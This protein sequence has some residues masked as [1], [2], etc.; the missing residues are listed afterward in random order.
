MEGQK[1]EEEGD[2]GV[3]YRWQGYSC[4]VKPERIFLSQPVRQAALGTRHGVLLTKDGLVYSFGE[5]PWKRDLKSQ[6]VEPV[7]ESS[8]TGHHVVRVSTGNF[9]CGAVTEEGTVHMWG[10]NSHGQCGIYGFSV[11]PNPT[12]VNIVDDEIVPPELVRIQDVACGAEHTLA[13]SRKHEVWAWGS[14]CQLGLVTTVFPVWKAEKVEHLSGRYV[15]Q[16]VCG[17]F[18][19]LALV[20]SQPRPESLQQSE[21]KCGECKQPIYTFIDKD[22]H[23][24]ISDNHYCPLGVELSDAKQGQK[25]NQESPVLVRKTE[26][27]AHGSQSFVVL[28]GDFCPSESP[29]NKSHSNDT[30]GDKDVDR[31]DPAAADTTPDSSD[32]QQGCHTRSKSSLYPDEQALKDYLKRISEQSQSEQFEAGFMKGSRHG[33]QPPS[34]QTSLKDSYRQDQDIKPT[35]PSL[36]PLDMSNDIKS[37]LSDDIALQPLQ[38]SVTDSVSRGSSEDMDISTDVLTCNSCEEVSD[39]SFSTDRHL[40]PH[41]LLEAKKSVSL[42]DIR[43]DYTD[44]HSRRRS[45]PGL[46]SPVSPAV[47]LR[48]NLAKAGAIN[49][50]AIGNSEKENLLQSLATEVWTWGRGQEGQ[51]GHGDTLPRLQPLCI[52][53]L[54]KK[55]V[56]KIVAGSYHSLALTAQCQVYSWGSNKLGQLGHTNSLR[57]VPQHVKMPDGIRVW[58]VAAGQTHTVLLADAD[59][60]EPILYYSGGQMQARQESP[61]ATYTQTPTLLPFFTNL[62]FV[63]SIFAGGPNCV[64]LVDRN[65]MGY[66]ATVHKMATAE[67]KF[68]CML[69]RVKNQILHPILARD[70]V[71]SCLSRTSMLLF[72]TMA[73]KY[74]RLCHLIG[75]HATSLTNFLQQKPDVKT[76]AIL[77]N[78]DLFL[79]T[80]KKH[81]SSVGNFLV[82]GGF[83]SLVKPSQECFGKK[84]DLVEKLL[85]LKEKKLSPSDLLVN[86]FYMPLQYLHN[87]SSL[88]M[89][90]AN[91]FDVNSAEYQMIQDCC[92]QYEVLAQLLS[93][94]RKE[95]ESTYTF[96]RTFSEKSLESLRKP[97]RRL[98]CESINKGLTLQNAGRFSVNSFFLFNDALVHAQGTISSKKFFS[99]HHIYLLAT[100]WAEPISDE[101]LGLLGLK[102]TT[103]EENFTLLASSPL[104]KGKWLRAINQAVEDVLGVGQDGNSFSL[105]GSQR[106]ETPISR[107]ATYTFTKEGRLKDAT[108]T[109]RWLSGKP[110]GSGTLKWPDGRVYCGTFKNAL[111]DGFGDCMMPNKSFS[112]YDRYKGHWKEGKMHGFGTFWYANGEVYEGSFQ[113]NLRHGHGMLSSGRLASSSSSVFVGQWVH[114]KKSGYGILDNITKGEKYMGM[115]LEDQRQ[116]NAV[117]VTQFGLY[118]EG[119]FSNNKMM[120]TGLLLCD[121]D[122]SLEGAFSE[123][124][125]LNGKGVLSIPNGDSFDGNFVGKWGDELKVTGTFTKLC[126]YETEKTENKNF[127]VGRYAV[128]A[129]Q[130]WIAVFEECWSRLGCETPGVGEKEK[131]WE[132]I[133][134]ILTTS[135]RQ[136]CDSPRALSRSQCKMLESLE[137]IPKHVGPVTA[138]TYDI[139]RRYLIKAC[140]TPLHPLGWLLETLVTVYRMTYVG[141]GSNR[142]LLKQAVEEIQSYLKRI[143]QLVRFLFPGLPEEGGFIPDSEWRTSD[144]VSGG[145]RSDI[146]EQGWIVSSNT[147]LLPVLLPR[148]YPPLF[149]L[150]TLERE[151]EELVYWECVLRLNK[152]PDL[153]LLTFLGVSQKFW[154]VSIS[155]LGEIKEVLPNSMNACFA[156]AVET[157]QQIS[158][159]FTPA[160]KLQVIHLT[161]EDITQEVQSMLGQSFLWCMDDLFPVFLYVVLRARIRNLGTEVSVIEDFM[162]PA[163]QLGELGL[164]FTTLKACYY[165]IQREKTTGI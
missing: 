16:I 116:G 156:T 28:P 32:S 124:W 24:I 98:L 21:D 66:I 33:S 70:S 11:V 146:T 126:L 89:N 27:S 128:P 78:A 36:P 39:E 144:L 13:L 151:S 107:T 53:S 108:Y 59:R 155:L 93:K 15:V 18:H 9:H 67:R 46:L 23:V 62:G 149:T 137:V 142:R 84:L 35:F 60:L 135:R 22:D 4:T 88:L 85:D 43:L 57:T 49:S 77:K 74:S 159:T 154:P 81:S 52:K 44:G 95:A 131:A 163:L 90:L 157:L 139:I 96:W 61:T 141:V 87:Y 165:Q 86:L 121:D 31:N 140:D 161:F 150:Y 104:E 162:D 148:L 40:C 79:D 2:R 6:S 109:G 123:D 138:E 14:G 12:P 58:D 68:Y 1:R 80:Y 82:M 143:F 41:K 122:T 102:L 97:T 130:K 25:S 3:P 115:W 37:N 113:E 56:I 110:H 106:A 65:V 101:T 127:E 19:S 42:T 158:T 112:R 164:M 55:E 111:E 132:N 17:E 91:C 71:S 145:T 73:G 125:T 129:D 114:D 100:L 118:Y 20:R 29:Q 117:V 26:T 69:S 152:Q 133:A 147:L 99:S 136:Q 76:L 48:C 47:L 72:Q 75:K 34:R 94:Q 63:S 119:E 30:A 5:L 105:S 51:L 45:L 54:S 64:A 120:G 153:S 160:D 92:L 38:D 50:T 103:P 7:L 83:Q 10:E 134:V 8:L